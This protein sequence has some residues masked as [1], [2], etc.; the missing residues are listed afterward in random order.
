MTR[1]APS[2]SRWATRTRAHKLLHTHPVCPHR[3]VSPQPNVFP[4]CSRQVFVDGGDKYHVESCEPPV[5]G[6]DELVTQLNTNNDFAA[7]VRAMRK[8]FKALA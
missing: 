2:S 8:R 7:F 5:S 1:C 6:M 3:V 4:R